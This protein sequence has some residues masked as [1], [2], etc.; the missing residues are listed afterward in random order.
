MSSLEPTT[1]VKGDS[2]NT[3]PQTTLAFTLG[4]F[5]V[6][7]LAQLI[8]YAPMFKVLPAGDDFPVLADIQRGNDQGPI[9]IIRESN[10]ALNYRPIRG[11]GLW[12][13][14]NISPLNRIFWIH[15]LHFIGATLMSVAGLLWMR[16]LPLG[17]AGVVAASIVT[18]LH[19][20][21]VAAI[22]SLD[23]VDSTIS[24]GLLWMGVW[25]IYRFREKPLVCATVAFVFFA[26]GG[27]TKEYIFALVPLGAWTLFYFSSHA[28]LLRMTVVVSS[29][30]ICFVLLMVV[31]NL[32]IP[33]TANRGAD[34]LSFDP[35]QWA[36]N[37]ASFGVGLLL[38]GNT[39]WI[40]L[41]RFS[42]LLLA[43]IPMIAALCLVVFGGVWKFWEINGER[44]R[45]IIY[46]LTS[47]GLAMFPMIVM[48]HISE[49]YLP[50]LVIPFALLCGIAADGWRHYSFPAQIAVGVISFAL[51]GNSIWAIEDKIAGM[52]RVGDRTDLQMENVLAV[53][54]PDARD[55]KIAIAYN[56]FGMKANRRYSVFAM[57]DEI[58]LV[59]PN[60]LDWKAPGRGLK[61]ETFPNSM[62][63][64][65]ADAKFDYYV[66]WDH[67]NNRMIMSRR[68]DLWQ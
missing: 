1:V 40:F 46:L 3:G 33:P 19:P 57:G 32:T 34:Y 25:S 24:T 38:P 54:P 8:V 52:R 6:S 45:W 35:G 22:C 55:V 53:L 9:A 13:F 27:V 67:R 5:L 59:H 31:R 37:L 66:F 21:L 23:G 20:G 10:S 42:P 16:T 36:S 47:I 18:V 62:T 65:A 39:V 26:L 17:R 12:A 29:M 64:P 60:V 43:S 58:M 51:L 49:M 4:V 41:N 11:L 2:D 30:M 63:P 7:W 50:P 48:F 61:I 14:A 56:T 15:A 44:H 28:R 68:Q